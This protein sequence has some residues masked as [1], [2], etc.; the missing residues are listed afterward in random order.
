M[1]TAVLIV[2]RWGNATILWFTLQTIHN[3]ST[4][5]KSMCTWLTPPT[6]RRRSLMTIKEVEHLGKFI[7]ANLSHFFFW[8]WKASTVSS[9]EGSWPKEWRRTAQLIISMLYSS[10]LYIQFTKLRLK[11]IKSAT[12]VHPNMSFHSVSDWMSYLCHWWLLCTVLGSSYC[13][14]GI[15]LF[16]Y[17]CG[18]AWRSH[19]RAMPV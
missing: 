13:C 12:H 5:T 17:A 3:P 4:Y 8:A 11:C 16:M 6:T 19:K 2:Q 10:P 1:D 14:P 18:R 15:W 9:A 7:G